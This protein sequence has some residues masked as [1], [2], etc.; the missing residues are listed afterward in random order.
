MQTRPSWHFRIN[1]QV[2]EISSIFVMKCF[3]VSRSKTCLLKFILGRV[4]D[5]GW[6]FYI[7][8]FNENSSRL[9]RKWRSP[10]INVTGAVFF[11]MCEVEDGRGRTSNV[12][13]RPLPYSTIH[14]K[15][16]TVGV[17]ASVMSGSGMSTKCVVPSSSHGPRWYARYKRKNNNNATC[18][19]IYQ[20]YFRTQM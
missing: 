5:D 6:H 9:I 8:I 15:K 10:D 3:K 4:F 7:T 19:R 11:F 2:V 20:S 14:I 17:E 1:V 12:N 13:V 18:W 16:N